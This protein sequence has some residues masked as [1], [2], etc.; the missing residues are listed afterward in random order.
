MSTLNA[1]HLALISKEIGTS[2]L[3]KF[4]PISLCNVIYKIISKVV[5]NRLKPLLPLLISLEQS[6]YVEGF[7]ILDGI[8]LSHEVFH[9]LKTTKTPGMILKLDLSK[10]FNKLSH[11]FIE[12]MLLSFSFCQYWVQW[13]LSLISSTF[14]SILVNGSP[15]SMLL[16]SRGI[17]LGDP[18]SPFLFIL[19]VE[20]LWHMIQSTM[21]DHTLRDLSLHNSPSMAY[22]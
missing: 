12:E 2:H 5:A 6:G 22:Q 10:A 19:M 21:I 16:S 9:S 17:C 20:G 1:T 11:F 14:F 3:G 13:I 18:L 8:I 7:K 15:S 4:W